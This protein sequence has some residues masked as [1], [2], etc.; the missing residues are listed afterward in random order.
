MARVGETFI[1]PEDFKG[2]LLRRNPSASPE[3]KEAA[4]QDLIRT[5]TLLARAREAGFDKNPETVARVNRLIAS[6]YEEKM[7]APEHRSTNSPGEID[8]YYAAHQA[9][10]IGPAKVRVAEILLR[11]PRKASDEKQKEFQDKAELILQ[12][13]KAL[14]AAA[15]N[16][17][18]LARE[19]S[20][21]QSSRYQGGD[22]GWLS[23]VEAEARW[24]S[25]IAATLFNLSQT[26]ALTPPLR[27]PEGLLLF[28]LVGKQDSKPKPLPEVKELVAYRLTRQKEAAAQKLFEEKL[29]SGL[30]IEINRPL[31]D[32][33]IA[34]TT[35][36]PSAPP[37]MPA[38]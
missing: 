25:D 16:F 14:P 18:D 15:T 9:D 31:A 8:E 20:E 3:Q 22:M 36:A 13:A 17:G 37:S 32:S 27:G 26:G 28:K 12:K 34:S 38:R 19:Y 7:R 2:E 21:E 23:K 10:F 11:V 4:L 35:N 30:K 6:A 33:I 29:R 24:G 5:Q 1:S